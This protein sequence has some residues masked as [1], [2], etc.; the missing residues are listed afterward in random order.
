MWNIP[1]TL[2]T[3]QYCGGCHNSIDFD[4]TIGSHSDCSLCGHFVHRKTGLK[5]SAISHSSV[6]KDRSSGNVQDATEESNDRATVEESCT[7]CGNGLMYFYTMQLRS[8]DEGQTVFYEC[9]KCR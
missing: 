1:E 6:R 8:V 2:S 5:A 4:S 3:L 9:T 7:Q